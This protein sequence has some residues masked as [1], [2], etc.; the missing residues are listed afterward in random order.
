MRGIDVHGAK[1]RIDWRA[2]AG[3]GYRFAYVKASEGVGFTDQRIIENVRGARDAGLHVGPYHFARP[4]RG[5]SSAKE[6]AHFLEVI[7]GL[8]YDLLPALDIEKGDGDLSTWALDFLTRVSN[9]HR[10]ACPLYTYSYFAPHLRAAQL[11]AFPLWLARYGTTRPSAPRPWDHWTIWQ[12]S[13]SGAVAGVPGACDIDQLDDE[14]LPT[15][16]RTEGDD[17]YLDSDRER[18]ERM[19]QQVQ[20]IHDAIY[21]GH[22]EFAQPGMEGALVDVRKKVLG[23]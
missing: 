10:R 11:G 23:L 19:A 2:V 1:G 7:D 4:D 13:S 8:P 15:L 3:D 12:S 9:A 17:M 14:R 21:K 6:A 22:P 16:M 18:D 20:E 5:S